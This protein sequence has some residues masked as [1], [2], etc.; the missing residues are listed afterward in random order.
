M[1]WCVA[2]RALDE[3]ADCG[4]LAGSGWDGMEPESAI[5]EVSKVRGVHIPETTEQKSCIYEV[6]ASVR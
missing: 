2:V 3:R 5:E 6:A 1:F 4:I